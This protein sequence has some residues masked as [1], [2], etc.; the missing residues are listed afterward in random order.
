M[1]TM[2]VVFVF[3][4]RCMRA[5]GTSMRTMIDERIMMGAFGLMGGNRRGG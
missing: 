5:R 4:E 3:G 1:R 2:F